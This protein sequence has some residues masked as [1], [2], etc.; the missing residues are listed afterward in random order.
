M[1]DKIDFQPHEDGLDFQLDFQPDGK[2]SNM[3]AIGHGQGVAAAASGLAAAIPTGFRMLGELAATGSLDEAIKRSEST[4]EAATYKPRTESGKRT[5]AAINTTLGDYAHE[6][7]NK[8]AGDTEYLTQQK[9]NRGEKLT[10]SDY[11]AENTERF[12]GDVLGSMYVPGIPIG[13]KGG[14]PSP[15]VANSPVDIAI[16]KQAELD[17]IKGK[18][19]DF[20]AAE[21]GAV[22]SP[23]SKVEDPSQYRT[24]DPIPEDVSAQRAQ[25]AIDHRNQLQTDE[26]ARN[27]RPGMEATERAQQ[28]AASTGYDQWKQDMLDEQQGRTTRAKYSEQLNQA[29]GDAAGTI[30]VDPSAQAFRGDPSEPV[31]RRSLDNLKETY[32]REKTWLKELPEGEP[33]HGLRNIEREVNKG[34]TSSGPRGRQRGAVDLIVL[35]DGVNKAFEKIDEVMGR[36]SIPNAQAK[37][38][39]PTMKEIYGKTQDPQVISFARK[40]LKSLGYPMD[41]LMAFDQAITAAHRLKLG[42]AESAMNRNNVIPFKQRGATGDLNP[43]KKARTIV[44]DLKDRYAKENKDM[45]PEDPKS[46]DVISNAL[47]EGK[48]SGAWNNAEAGASLAAMKRDSSAIQG[49]SEIIQNANK[50]ADLKIRENVFPTEKA[51]RK[52]SRVEVND[53]AE[54]FKTEMLQ[55]K[56]FSP[57]AL[58]HL[59]TRQLEAYANMRHMFEDI[60]RIENEARAVKGQK[61]IAEMEAYL[62]SRWDGDFRRPIYQTILNKDGSP[63]I[64]EDGTPER[65]IVW[66]LAANTK[67]GLE[68]QTKALLKD[69]PDLGFEPK[70]DHVV[71]YYKRQTDLQSN[72]T[73]I[74]DIIGRDDPAAERIQKAAEEQSV[75]EAATFLG[76]EKHFKD[77]VGV[78]GF[79]GDRPGYSGT[80]EALAMFQQQIQRAKNGYKWSELQKSAQSIK[81]I[82]NNP[83]LMDQ[84]PNNL[85]YIKDYWKQNIGYG[86]HVAMAHL[87]DAIR[88]LGISPALINSG[89]NMTK[90]YFILNKLAVNTG[91]AISNLVQTANVLP[92]MLDIFHKYGGNPATALGIGVSSGMAA[93]LGHY[94]SYTKLGESGKLFTFMPKE[95]FINRAFKYAEDNGVASRALYDESP[96]ES[97]FSAVGKTANVMGRTMSMP[98]TLVR[99]M[100]YMTFVRMLKDSGKFAKDIDIFQRAEEY[101]NAAMVDYRAGEKPMAFSKLG[102]LGNALNTLQTYP[103]NYYQQWNH[104]IRQSVKGN[105]AP[106]LAMIAVQYAVAGAM[107]IP[108]FDDATKAISYFK[109]NMANTSTYVKMRESPF[110]SNPKLWMVDHF[111]DA[112][113]YG[114]LSDKSGLGISSRVAAPGAGQMIQAPGGPAMDIAKQVGNIGSAAMDPTN[115]S[116]WAQA[117]MSAI[118]PGLQGNL[119]QA[120][121]MEGKTFDKRTANGVEHNIYQR[122]GNIESHTGVYVRTPQEENLRRFGLRSQKETVEREVGYASANDTAVAEKHAKSIPDAFYDA[123]KRGDQERAKELYTAYVKLTGKGISQDAFNAQIQQNYMTTVERSSTAAKTV[124]ALKDVARMQRIIKDL[125][126][127]YQPKR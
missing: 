50:R 88:D 100:A 60:L 49:G 59:T 18:D 38:A 119:E 125:E 107:G 120:P 74:L 8:F 24:P 36:I 123:A 35:K 102:I 83:D 47:A 86:E 55:G 79:I 73:T 37:D 40:E 91:F 80:S 20:Q 77:K 46:E 53:L 92:H 19:I 39:V 45:I 66:Y 126:D 98:E 75:N 118:P 6:V 43:G 95:A 52:L 71:R 64:K 93:A 68:A 51:F 70:D 32:V 121:F 29:Q 4:S 62:S 69:H 15:E 58:D 97:S 31:A 54:L 117:G 111:G 13:R 72:L 116:K 11:K 41:V 82:V 94:L 14:K 56:R 27:T 33:L 5:E 12:V 16:K 109:D 34:I 127:E 61:P 112:G 113:V 110:W 3:E 114:I 21:A 25:E 115:G 28:E 106:I 17:A 67:R 99:S 1:S 7:S 108:G 87:E 124:T 81:E 96:I 76:H 90:T 122:P 30:Y 26:V 89:V 42:Q 78:R 10:P 2:K 22:E 104:F 9:M 48:D 23:T 84:Q 101:T 44:D 63:G 85:K 57:E 105:P 103:T 65:K